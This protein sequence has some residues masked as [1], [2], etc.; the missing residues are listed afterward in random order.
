MAR[1]GKLTV[2][3]EQGMTGQVIRVRTTGKRGT[4]LLNTV[5][6]DT[7]YPSQSPSDTAPNFWHDA[8]TKASA[9]F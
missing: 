2:F 6:T 1:I 4:I 7:T 9:T 3:V 8:L 5:S